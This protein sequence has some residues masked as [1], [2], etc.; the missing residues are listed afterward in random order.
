MP[1][2]VEID[3]WW[4]PASDRRAREII[5]A[6]LGPAIGWLRAHN[7]R[8]GSIVQAGG[9]TGV[10]PKALMGLFDKVETYEPDENNYWCLLANLGR[11]DPL[12]AWRGALGEVFDR[13]AVIEHEPGNCGAH[14]IGAGDDFPIYALDDHRAQVDVIWLDVEGSE[15]PA[16]RGSA[17]TLKRD[18]PMVIVELKGI[19]RL[20]GYEDSEVHDYLDGFGYTLKSQHGNDFMFTVEK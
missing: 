15:L 20:Y 6:E 18:H 17:E 19:G 3:G 16:L 13:G 5:L 8:W 10:Y 11:G 2:I 4:W 14:R 9:N 7:T 1:D 12:M